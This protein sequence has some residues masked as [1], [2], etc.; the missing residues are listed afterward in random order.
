MRVLVIGGSGYV[1]SLVLPILAETHTLRN[2]DRRP[3]AWPG[4]IAITET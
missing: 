2:F 4:Q 1:A 3:P